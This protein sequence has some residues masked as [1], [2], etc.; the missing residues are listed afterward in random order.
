ML[1]VD[2]R[3]A[4][5]S[6]LRVNKIRCALGEDSFV[7]LA[8]KAKAGETI[9]VRIMAIEESKRRGTDGKACAGQARLLQVCR[10]RTVVGCCWPSYSTTV[11]DIQ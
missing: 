5:L 8:E 1:L 6:V 11:G 7:N 10:E 4:Q 9:T 3:F 2:V